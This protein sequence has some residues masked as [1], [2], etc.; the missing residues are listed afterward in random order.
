MFI[1]KRIGR[2]E[3]GVNVKQV[4]LGPIT[5]CMLGTKCEWN[6]GLED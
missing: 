6:G 4:S 1:M 3:V 5:K 2:H